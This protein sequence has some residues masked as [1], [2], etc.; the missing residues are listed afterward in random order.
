MDKRRQARLALSNTYFATA[1]IDES[2]VII[3][4]QKILTKITWAQK[5]F[6]RES[7]E[8][9]FCKKMGKFFYKNLW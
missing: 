4:F 7:G 1:L 5:I 2:V 8:L 9:F 6:D 3:F